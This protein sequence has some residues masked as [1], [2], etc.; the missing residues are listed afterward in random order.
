VGGETRVVTAD[1]LWACSGYYDYDQGYAP[2]LEGQE[3]F[4]GRL[5]HPQHWPEDLDFAGRRVVVI[6]SG[7]TAVTLVPAMACAFGQGRNE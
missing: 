3:R 7:A 4:A 2:H 1:F 5:V 6:G